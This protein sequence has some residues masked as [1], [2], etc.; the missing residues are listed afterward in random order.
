MNKGMLYTSQTGINGTLFE[1]NRF[2]DNYMEPY[3][4][5]YWIYN[6]YDE[7]Y[8]NTESVTKTFFTYEL[9]GSYYRYVDV[10]TGSDDERATIG[11]VENSMAPAGATV[12]GAIGGKR[13]GSA[14][15]ND[16]S[17]PDQRTMIGAYGNTVI[18]LVTDLSTPRSV[19]QT[20]A[21]VEELGYD[22][23]YFLHLDGGGST[24]MRVKR[25]SGE[26]DYYGG[27][28]GRTIQNM[29]SIMD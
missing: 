12:R 8:H 29:V 6:D 15:H 19:A 1:R 13:F 16:Y 22:P 17:T 26:V 5:C 9:N 7:E 28:G 14:Y 20:L 27:S 21:D 11:T 10:H 23:S 4:I 3:G 24:T 25:A 18:M 2:A